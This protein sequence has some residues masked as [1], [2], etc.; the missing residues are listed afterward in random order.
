MLKYEKFLN[1]SNNQ[2]EESENIIQNEDGSDSVPFRI[3]F[4]DLSLNGNPVRQEV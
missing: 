4:S 1:L 3:K 2:S